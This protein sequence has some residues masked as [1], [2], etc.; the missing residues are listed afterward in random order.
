MEQTM[1]TITK[2]RHLELLARERKLIALEGA[3]VDNWEGWDDAM[4]ILEEMENEEGEG[5]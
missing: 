3:G 5:E 4:E 1:V 2:E